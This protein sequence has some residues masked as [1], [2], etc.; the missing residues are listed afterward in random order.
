MMRIGDVG[1]RIEQAGRHAGSELRDRL[2][3]VLQAA[4]RLID[5]EDRWRRPVILG[6]MPITAGQ[7][8]TN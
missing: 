8:S 5:P 3:G 1:E 4:A 6:L 2:F 7:S